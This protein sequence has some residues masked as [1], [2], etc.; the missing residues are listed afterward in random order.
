MDAIE[1]M[2]YAK[3]L[4]QR[5]DERRREEEELLSELAVLEALQVNPG[6]IAQISDEALEGWICYMRDALEGED[7]ALARRII[8]HFVAKIVIKNGTGTLYYTFPFTDEL[9]MSSYGNLDLK[10]LELLTSSMPLKRSPS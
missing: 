2:G 4:Q 6:H 8:Q 1:N 7:R 3:H 10:R 5:Y 9:Y